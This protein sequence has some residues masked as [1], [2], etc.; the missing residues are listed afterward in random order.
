MMMIII[1]IDNSKLKCANSQFYFI[2]TLSSVK[3]NH[4]WLVGLVKNVKR[5]SFVQRLY[6][7]RCKR[8][9]IVHCNN[10]KSEGLIVLIAIS[11][12]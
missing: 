11:F 12:K 3:T 5:L 4:N 6:G 8:C 2:T 10:L 7:K 1:I 9:P